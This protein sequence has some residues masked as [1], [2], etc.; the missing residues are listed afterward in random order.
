MVHKN[1]QQV[2]SNLP[3]DEIQAVKQLIRLQRERIIVI[4]ACD[5]GAGLI[6]LD[7]KD[8]M[9]A[10]YEHLLS[11]IKIK[12]D[13]PHYYYK[14]VDCLFL[15]KA[16]IE[17]EDVLIE[18]HSLDLLSKT[19]YDTMNPRDCDPARFYCNFKV[20]KLHEPGQTPPVRPIIS[21][22][23]S[24]TEMIGQYVDHHIKDLATKHSS[25]LQDT[26]HFLRVLESIRHGEPLPS[27]SILVTFDVTSAYQN[28]PQNDGIDCLYETLEEREN[29]NIPSEQISKLMELILKYNLFEFDKSIYQQLIGTSM[30]SKPAPSYANIYLAKRIDNE[31]LRLGLKYGQSGNSALLTMRRFLDDIFSIFRGTTKQLHN[32]FDELNKIHPT[33]KFT[34]NHTSP[35]N[36]AAKDRCQCQTQISIPFLDTLCT[37]IQDRN[38]YFQK[39]N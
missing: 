30:G 15:E 2:E 1:R 11:S 24:T 16:K 32:F 17:I 25:Y 36:E 33:L 28:I 7:F 6:L 22:S 12:E 39:G 35:E 19:E 8:Y 26:P 18:A 27:D 13:Q 3:P 10:C 5:K 34:L 23:G 20:H 9:K 37:R 29:K 4:K 38:R 31:I 21:G 14:Q